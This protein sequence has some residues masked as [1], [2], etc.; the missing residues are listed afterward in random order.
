MADAPN[1]TARLAQFLTAS[2]WEDIPQPVRHEAMRSLLDWLGCALGGCRDEAV[3]RVLAA[4]AGFSGPPEATVIGRGERLDILNAALVNAISSNIL[5]FDDTHL[6]TVIHPTSPVAAALLAFAEHRRTTG[7]RFLHAFALGVEAECRIGNAISPGHYD[8][9]WHITATCGVFGAA[10]AVGKLLGL[11]PREMTWALGA[12]ATQSAGLVEMLGSMAK[13][14]GVGA[15]ARNGLFA[16]LLA[17]KGFTGPEQAIEGVR[18]F[19]NVLG[20]RPDF[21]AITDRLG[22]DWALTQNAHKPYPCGIVMHPAL[23]GCIDL[24]RAHSIP[25]ERIQRIAL[26]VNPLAVARTSRPEPR[27]RLEARLSLQHGAA[28]ALVHGVAGIAQFTDASIREPAVAVLRGKADV[29][30]DPALGRVEAIVEVHTIDGRIL[31]T[32]VRHARGS[33]ECP[34]TDV[35]IGAKFRELAAAGAPGCHADR[36]IALVRSLETAD[37]AAVLARASVPTG[38]A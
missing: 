25:P 19:A 38:V 7:E 21:H 18:G 36:I 6:R 20:E 5:D 4:L 34:M 17:A 14:L 11:S 8:R 32:H 2:R 15:A 22:E 9:G 27:T 12:A 37:D 13:S 28:V 30:E 16:A 35:E 23:D 1:V 33:L 31:S 29:R 10:A 26:K 24:H 3:D